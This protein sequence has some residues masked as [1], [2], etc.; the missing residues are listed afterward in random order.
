VLPA[1]RDIV[2]AP[3]F[4]TNHN[5]Q[6]LVEI[7]ITRLTSAIRETRTIE[8]HADALVALLETC[9]NYN[10]RPVNG[11]PD[12]PHAKIASDVMSC[13]FL[14]YRYVS[15]STLITELR[16]RWHRPWYKQEKKNLK[17]RIVLEMRHCLLMSIFKKMCV[18]VSSKMLLQ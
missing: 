12:P 3:D 1:I 17:F 11:G 9:L 13:I 6:S 10:L 7:C 5:D 2:S 14:N 15:I 4:P 18:S 16:G 8:H